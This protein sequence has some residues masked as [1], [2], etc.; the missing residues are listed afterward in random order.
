MNFVHQYIGLPFKT[1]GRSREE[2]LDCWGLVRLIY[3]EQFSIDLPS[4]NDEYN[5]S[6]NNLQTSSTIQKHWGEWLKV[7]LEEA[8]PGDV[9]VLRLSGFP[10]HVGLVIGNNKMLHIIEGT[11][12]VIEDYQ[13]R[14]WE[15]RVLGIFRHERMI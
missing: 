1:C 12:S 9:I 10:T 2:G 4:Y 3:K 14:L 15:K 5:D 13:S 6:H 11:D 8:R 7:P